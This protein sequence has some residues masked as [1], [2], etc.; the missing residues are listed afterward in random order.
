MTILRVFEQANGDK[1]ARRKD[2]GHQPRHAIPQ[3]ETLQHPHEGR[4]PRKR[5]PKQ[6][7]PPTD[8]GL[9]LRTGAHQLHAISRETR[10]FHRETPDPFSNHAFSLSLTISSISLLHTPSFLWRHT[11]I[12]PQR[13]SVCFGALSVYCPLGQVSRIASCDAKLRGAL[14]R[15]S[16]Q[17]LVEV[18]R[19]C[20]EQLAK[21]FPRVAA[22]RAPV[23]VTALRG[24]HTKLREAT[25]VEFAAADVAIFVSTLPL[26]FDDRVRLERNPKSRPAD[27]TVIAVQYHE[28]QK[29]RGRQ[30]HQRPVRVG[31]TAVTKSLTISIFRRLP[32]LLPFRAAT[33]EWDEV[34][35]LSPSTSRSPSSYSLDIPDPA[36]Q[37]QSTRKTRSSLFSQF[38]PWLDEWT[39]RCW[40]ISSAICFR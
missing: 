12:L 26:E 5:K 25:V 31:D 17:T 36:G 3:T 24:G 13:N 34:R 9:V 37:A 40:S 38:E 33:G 22:A 1:A 39:S 14:K 29:S 35:S 21:F 2:A 7:P 16:G 19:S 8:T 23:Q 30:I 4:I 15:S 18:E 11:C 20:A 32:G 10:A 27:A 6:R 28:G